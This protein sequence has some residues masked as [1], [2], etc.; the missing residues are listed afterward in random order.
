MLNLASLASNIHKQ[1]RPI[2]NTIVGVVTDVTRP[3]FRPKENNWIV[4]VK[5]ID[6]SLNDLK[7][8]GVMS[9]DCTV[10]LISKNK[11]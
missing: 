11:S 6:E 2:S 5:V 4:M 3:L 7:V 8:Y 9:K 1:S 10:Y